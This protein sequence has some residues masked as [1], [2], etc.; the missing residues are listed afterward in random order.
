MRFICFLSFVFSFIVQ[1]NAQESLSITPDTHSHLADLEQVCRDAYGEQSYVADWSDVQAIPNIVQWS[2]S[3]GF[4]LNQEVYLRQ[5]GVY[6]YSANRHYFMARHNGNTPGGWLV[7]D[8]IA[9][10]FI[11]L[12]SWQGN[13]YVL[14]KNTQIVS[15]PGC[16]DPSSC[17]YNPAATEDDNLC[18]TYPGDL[19]DDGNLQTLNDS[20]NENCDCVGQLLGCTDPLSCE[21]NPDAEV[22]DGSC[23]TYPG[24]PC[25]D[26][27]P[28][29]IN[30]LIDANC[31]CIGDISG[32][33]DP[34]SCQYDPEATIDD[35]SCL[36]FELDQ[37][38][39]TLTSTSFNEQAD[40]NQQCIDEFGP[41]YALAD[42]TDLEQITNIE[43]WADSI[44][45]GFMD[46]VWVQNNGEFFWSGNRHYLMQRHDNSLPG[47]FLAHD[48]IN[49]YFLSLGSFYDYVQPALCATTCPEAIPGCTDPTACNYN[50]A[51][52]V[53]DES[54]VYPDE[55]YLDC[56]G[57]CLNDADGD[58]ICDE[59]EVPGCTDILACN[60]VAE[61]TDDD[62]SCTYPELPY[63]D[64][65]GN[66]LN[67]GDLDGICDEEEISGCT[68]I[69]A[70][71]YVAEATD[72]DGSCEYTGCTYDA[73]ENYNP[74]ATIDDGSCVFSEIP[75][76][77]G[78]T[79][80]MACNYDENSDVDDQSCH[81]DCYGC[82]YEGAEN[83]DAAA[84]RDDGSCVYSQ[85]ACGEGTYFDI[86]T[87]EC[88]PTPNEC[89]E[90]LNSD[91]LVNSSDLLQFLG[92]F[93][94][95]CE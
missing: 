34:L 47:S 32:C 75:V 68:D 55:P 45:I 13:R 95:A 25:D 72:D 85:I 21:Y 64:C 57:N 7:H 76:V 14:C 66:C 26:G 42:W 43:Q 61:A 20:V 46:Q 30:D 82:T 11:D 38:Q 90:D 88:L 53:N 18:F 70:V 74:V 93:G 59:N 12:G 89:P 92:T 40:P 15:V 83:Y 19:C 39:F 41:E 24:D 63:L 5:N 48:N 80:P 44:G 8:D 33:T 87:G 78:C 91:G 9:N 73:A 27:N 3:I 65:E 6:F 51:A 50:Q 71:N 22:N 49:N 1:S 37:P 23:L 60:Y 10:N 79:D 31:N 29:S 58:L 52:N 86:A 69:E 67:D 62:N 16:M 56:N 4:M 54:C 84:T 36:T 17:D 94:T 2:D 81:F 77:Q 28:A 35:G